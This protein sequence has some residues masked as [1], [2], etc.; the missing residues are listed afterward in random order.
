MQVAYYRL[1]ENGIADYY[2]AINPTSLCHTDLLDCQL[3]LS[4][5]FKL[6]SGDVQVL[7]RVK[8]LVWPENVIRQDPLA[9]GKLDDV[10]EDAISDICAARAAHADASTGT[11]KLCAAAL[12]NSNDTVFLSVFKR[13][14]QMQMAGTKKYEIRVWQPRWNT[15][16]VRSVLLF[17]FAS[18]HI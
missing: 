6:A 9:V 4:G 2:T 7:H 17:S 10:I 16:L 5:A 14:L 15:M 8:G 18:R 3:H 12:Q 13:A 11:P 1:T